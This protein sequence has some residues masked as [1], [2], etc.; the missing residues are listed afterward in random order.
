MPLGA[1]AI[2]GSVS[3]CTTSI[4]VAA[5]PS[6][7][8]LVPHELHILVAGECEGHHEGPGAAQLAGGRI[9]Q[10]EARAEVHLRGLPRL[11]GQAHRGVGRHVAQ[12]RGNQAPHAGVVAGETMLAHQRGVDRHA[13][14]ALAE[15]ALDEWAVG[16]KGRLGGASAA[17][18]A[19][20]A[21]KGRV[22]SSQPLFRAESPS[23]VTSPTTT[24]NP[25]IRASSRL[26]SI[27]NAALH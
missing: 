12:H 16:R 26:S 24:P 27:K 4:R 22:S 21:G 13:G 18:I 5:Q 7:H 20:S 9:N 23:T 15:S 6:A 14:D 1:P 25:I 2:I 10:F 3:T 19:A 8:A 11:E 17:A